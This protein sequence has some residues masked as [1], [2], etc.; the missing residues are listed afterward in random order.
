MSFDLKRF[1]ELTNGK[2][3]DTELLMPHCECYFKLNND[4]YVESIDGNQYKLGEIR[5]EL[6]FVEYKGRKL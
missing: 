2:I 1:I 5:A 3:I 6:D 4:L